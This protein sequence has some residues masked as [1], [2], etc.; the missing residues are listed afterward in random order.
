MKRSFFDYFIRY[1]IVS[2]SSFY[3]IITN[4]NL[5][6]YIYYYHNRSFKE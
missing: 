3:L 5:I 4:T 6:S 2:S 1:H